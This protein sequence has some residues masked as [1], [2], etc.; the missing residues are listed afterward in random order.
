MLLKIHSGK[1]LEP[2]E[3]AEVSDYLNAVSVES[4]NAGCLEQSYS[5]LLVLGKAKHYSSRSLF[6]KFLDIADPLTVSLVLDTLCLEWGGA[7]HYI[8]NLLKFSFGVSWDY[9]EDVRETAIKILGEY[10]REAVLIS[11]KEI[12]KDEDSMSLSSRHLQVLDHLL[13]I[14]SDER[15]NEWIRRR[16]YVSLCRVYGREWED[17]PSDCESFD[18]E[19]NAEQVVVDYCKRL[20]SVGLSSAPSS[21]SVSQLFPS[22]R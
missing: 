14:F 2:E 16:A 13:K 4:C 3:I 10:V 1:K 8:E 15:Q 12:E 9:D 22:T 21:S 18:L 19:K 6:E 7:D 17:V 11:L 5:C 20:V